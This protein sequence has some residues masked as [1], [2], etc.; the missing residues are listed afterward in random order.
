MEQVFLMMLDEGWR[1]EE[2]E[3]SETV[4]WLRYFLEEAM[5][6]AHLTSEGEARLRELLEAI[7]SGSIEATGHEQMLAQQHLEQL[8]KYVEEDTVI[9]ADGTIVRGRANA[10]AYEEGQF[11]AQQ[12]CL[13][14]Q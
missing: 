3:R 14:G 6:F 10:A 2:A 7:C 1:N 9:C 4:H 8:D 13:G 11:F 12:H 5:P